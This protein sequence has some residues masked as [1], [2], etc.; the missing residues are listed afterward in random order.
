VNAYPDASFL[1]SLYVRRPQTVVA[2]SHVATMNE[3]IYVATLLRFEVA[4]A[5]RRAAFQNAISHQLAIA[6][7]AAFE[8]D[9]DNGVIVIPS[10]PWEA[11][12]QEAE[13]L[14]NAYTLRDGHRSFDILH[15]ATALTLKARE[16]L[17]FDAK[18]RALATAEGLKVKP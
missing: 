6:A 1:I 8:V 13:R 7:L 11:V 5:I 16:F 15:V 14:S 3:P 17:S 18:Q 9:I 12:H 10:V 2:S 4:Q